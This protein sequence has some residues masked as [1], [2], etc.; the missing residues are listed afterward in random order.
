MELE[1]LF[2]QLIHKCSIAQNDTL[3]A[4]YPNNDIW[5]NREL[6][7]AIND[8]QTECS[9]ALISSQEMAEFREFIIADQINIHI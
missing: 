3:E 9:N 1:E 4:A 5:V 8:I 7:E 2:D 6:M